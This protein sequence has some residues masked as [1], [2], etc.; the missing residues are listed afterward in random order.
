[1]LLGCSAIA[2]R[3]PCLREAPD[4]ISPFCFSMLGK[5]G[6]G[7]HVCVRGNCG[8]KCRRPFFTRNFSLADNRLLLHCIVSIL[9]DGV[10]Q[11]PRLVLLR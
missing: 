5:P 2:G 6:A 3:D 1:M 11:L 4:N 8:K 10:R 9:A 7:D